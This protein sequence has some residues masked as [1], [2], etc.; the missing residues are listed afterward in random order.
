MYTK[1]EGNWKNSP[2]NDPL[3]CNPNPLQ[4][5]PCTQN[6]CFPVSNFV[7]KK[8]RGI[9]LDQFF[10][11]FRK[12]H[13]NINDLIFS[14]KE[15]KKRFQ[16][17]IKNSYWHWVSWVLINALSTLNNHKYFCLL[18][19]VNLDPVRARYVTMTRNVILKILIHPKCHPLWIL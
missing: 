18:S 17:V 9:S 12:N 15:I 6:V 14:F 8:V 4:I 3:K 11:L 1:F 16:A 7:I 13:K 19:K 10:I 5:S 2:E